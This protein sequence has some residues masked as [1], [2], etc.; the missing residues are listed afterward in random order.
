MANQQWYLFT[1]P[2]VSVFRRSSHFGITAIFL[3][4]GDTP[5]PGGSAYHPRLR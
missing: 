3:D 1:R 4:C 5:F 2:A